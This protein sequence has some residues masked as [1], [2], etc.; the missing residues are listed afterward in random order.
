M[1]YLFLAL[2]LG[3]GL[4]KGYCGKKT[5]G[6]TPRVAD[7]MAVNTVRMG[8]CTGIGLLLIALQGQLPMLR[9]TLPLMA[10]AALSGIAT[11]AFVVSWL[12]AVRKG[13]YMLVE[14]F[15][16]L[17][18][19]I[20]LLAGVFFLQEPVR[21]VQ[22]VGFL[23]LLVATW[24]MCS[25]NGDQK[26]KLTASGF[27]LL[28]FCGVSSGLADLSQKL[29]VRT[30]PGIPAAVFNFYTYVFSAAVLL[31]VWLLLRKKE[32]I[33][34]R[35]VFPR[36]LFGYILLMAVCL[37][38]NS[39]FK[40]LAAGLLNISE[41]YPLNQGAALILASVMSAVA[42]REKLTP[43]GILG[44]LLSFVGLLFINLL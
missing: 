40:T 3:A 18:V 29:F 33:Q 42:F 14:V 24:V 35:T 30:A 11:A 27:L 15:L 23:I 6:Y 7:A 21:P 44:I 31:P 17:G 41:L 26:G 34:S 16:M 12:M 8:L 20:P 28:A 19:L 1:G 37:F 13:A 4:T 38:A 32:K 10:T 22:W 25:Y 39:Y 9:P 2:A 36:K 5:S 43:K